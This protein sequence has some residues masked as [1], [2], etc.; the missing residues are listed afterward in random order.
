MN[1]EEKVPQKGQNQAQNRSEPDSPPKPDPGQ[2]G[3]ADFQAGPPEKKAESPLVTPPKNGGQ[4]EKPDAKKRWVK[5]IL[6]VGVVI[7]VLVI[8]GVGG[9][10]AYKKWV[11]PVEKEKEAP[12]IKEEAPAEVGEVRGFATYQEVPVDIDPKVPPYRVEADL[13]NITNKNLFHLSDKAKELLVKNAFVVIP[14]IA[15]EFFDIYESN[16]YSGIANFVT[17]DSILHN[18]HLYFDFLLKTV[19]TQKLIPEY[20]SLVKSLYDGA[21][22]QASELSGTTWEN[23]AKRNK[24]FFAIIGELLGE[25]MNVSEDVKSIVDAE[26]ELIDDHKGISLSPLM[27][28]GVENPG[29]LSGYKEDYSQYIPRGHYTKTEDLKKYFK[30]MM[31]AGRMTFRL[32]EEDET[33]SAI[34]MTLLLNNSKS[35]FESWE[36][37]YE[38]TAF[39]VGKTDD[40]SFY[41]YADVIE[42]V[43]GS[44][45]LSAVQDDS[46]LATFVARA[47]DLEPPQ[48]NSI[49]IFDESIQPD[50]EE[51][52]KGFRFMGQRFTMD[53][54]IF[55]R[56][57][58]RETEGRMLPKGLDIPAAMGS[59]TAY[60]ILD[61]MGE[62]DYENYDTNMNKLREYLDSL[63]L[64]TWTQN[65]YWGWLYTLRPLTDE[66]GDG[67]P[68]FMQSDAWPYKEINTYLGNWTELK[69]D[70]ILYAKQAY[71]E[72][73]GGGEI[74]KADKGYVE[75]NPE[76]Y[77][78]LAALLKMTKNGLAARGL[79]E[80]RDQEG[81][82]RL[83][84]LVMN[85]KTISEKELKNESLTEEEYELIRAYGGSLEHFWLETL[86]DE[87]N[88]DRSSLLA[89]NP[90]A[91]VADVATD[92]NGQVLEEGT[93]W[94]NEIYVAVPV[95]GKIKIA[96][97]GV[98]SYYEFI[99]PMSE[100]L[101]DEAWREKINTEDIPDL[102]SWTENFIVERENQ[103]D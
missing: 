64:Q 12:L 2:G 22:S 37:I 99:V 101:T 89:G 35:N 57:M 49:P 53:A 97:G 41:E 25:D 86:R 77:A 50:R 30:G 75:P 55:Q 1:Q 13:S 62:T 31:Y 4:L 96:S 85:L 80:Q 100:R 91:I 69:H 29:P 44:T 58:H 65:L 60:N 47:G 76:L 71:A 90:A 52:I 32:K 34:L 21:S 46:K 42:E 61:E 67:Y 10:F 20:K 92:P 38:P 93:G 17:T 73:G 48:I 98:F 81:L 7:L 40:L 6:Q 43:Y 11:K 83:T 3:G 72:M 28:L 8:I 66:I 79:I 18:Y 45:D 82:D 94:V 103:V 5:A 63:N 54:S 87:E 51:E 56:L 33:K 88:L 9:F 19:E 68:A 95:E 78:R 16:R 23:A 36:K 39:F 26:L 15:S 14:S 74:P 59:E 84:E 102:P 24:A 27:N 70:T